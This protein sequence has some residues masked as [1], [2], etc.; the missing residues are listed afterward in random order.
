MVVTGAS[1]GIGAELARELV[2][3][4]HHVT[5][6]ARRVELLDSLVLELGRAQAL[7][8]D[9]SDAPARVELI[10][11]LLGDAG[12]EV[13]GL[14]NNAGYGSSG[15]FAELP[16]ES[17]LAEVRV[18]VEALHELTGALLPEMVRRGQGAILNV[19]SIAGFQPLPGMATYSATKAFVIAF[20]EALASELRGTGVSCT[21]LCPGPTRTD[22]SRIAGVADLEHLAG[23]TYADPARVACAGIEAMVTGRRL[24]I[25]RRRDRALA[26]V[27]RITPRALQLA[28]VRAATLGSLRAPLRSSR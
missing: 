14:C 28:A 23:S 21:V 24:V 11:R 4:G 10:E 19:A 17:E 9:L 25:P 3:R 22:F 1:S 2:R 27:G 18:N 7:P 5:I 16:I 8:C 12:R 6:V 20:S 26:A 15:A 13:V